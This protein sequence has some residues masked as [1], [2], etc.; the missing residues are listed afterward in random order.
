VDAVELMDRIA[1]KSVE[2][3]QGMPDYLKALSENVTA[4]L[5]ETKA[6]NREDLL[7]QT[8]EIKAL[9]KNCE[10]VKAIEFTDKELEYALF[11]T[12]RKGLFPAVGAVRETG[13]TVI[14]ED[15][16]FPI[17]DLAVGTLKLQALFSKYGYEKTP[18]FGH[19]LEG[20]L[21]FVFTP[22]FSNPV[23][24]QRYKDFM[25]EV[26]QLVAVDYQGSLKAEHGT[27]RNMTPFV[28]LEWGAE[29]Y[30]L[31]KKI[32]QIFD[33]LNILNPNV[34]INDDASAHIK[35]L[36]PLPAMHSL[37]DKCIECGF[38]EPV[39]PSNVL[40]FTPRH[41]IVASREIS[42]LH[43]E[44]QATL[45]K[46]LEKAYQY[47]GLDTCAACSLCSTLCPVGID[48]GKLIKYLRRQQLTALDNKKAD[49]VANNFAQFL[50]IVKYGLKASSLT[51]S[52]LGTTAVKTIN[53]TARK[54]SFNTIPKWSPAL[55][56]PVSIDTAIKM[57]E[58]A[59][60]VVYF[61][62]C[63]N[64]TM[65]QAK[66]AQE[67]RSVFDVTIAL[68]LKANFEV[69]IPKDVENLCC[70]LPFASKG[71]KQQSA[72]KSQELERS[73]NI[74]SKNGQYPI[75][76]D[77]SPCTKRMLGRSKTALKIYE[78]IEFT[79]KFLVDKLTFTKIDEPIVI[80]STCSA[81]KMG[82]HEKFVQ[83]ANLCSSQVI[84]PEDVTCC[85]FAGDKGFHFPELNE[86]ALRNLK[87]SI[88]SDVK[89]GF[90]T[91][92]TCEIGLSEHSGIEYNSILYLVDKVSVG[93]TQI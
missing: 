58:S 2:N 73:L 72:Q 13:T 69:I 56:Q 21:H 42:R 74:H 86:S 52:I 18:I 64:R 14:I 20:N 15:V 55:P 88:P 31:M 83:L 19:A 46:S 79:L 28:E 41:R 7:K 22:D 24:I 26:T 35:N 63:I 82:L 23:E 43:A 8:H 44:N 91:S 40:T 76:C 87:A 11:W 62:S 70:G 47:D 10:T 51:H 45:A 59:D 61:P 33:P 71:F 34:I 4:L 50:K 30:D 92:K 54:L 90:S 16:A 89:S 81:R 68:L 37:V 84:V 1:L 65:G 39:C 77:T 12:I 75:L 36:K 9:L 80:H 48:T 5:I 57:P 60:K 66:N 38:C 49:F 67:K 32:K 6:S 3:Q 25:A 17:E 85:G 27:G 78:P 53:T 93:K 29:A